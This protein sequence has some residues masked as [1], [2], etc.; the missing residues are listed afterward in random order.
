MSK[1]LIV[2]G[3]VLT[4]L[5]PYD[6]EYSRRN[7]LY[8]DYKE[9][10]D[11]LGADIEIKKDQ[12][13]NDRLDYLWEHGTWL[14]LDVIIAFATNNKYDKML[15]IDSDVVINRG[16]AY[17]VDPLELYANDSERPEIAIVY[18]NFLPLHY[19]TFD[20][21]S[22]KKYDFYEFMFGDEVKL[23]HKINSAMFVINKK[24]AKVIHETLLS[25]PVSIICG[26]ESLYGH[27]PADE[28][29]IELAMPHLKHEFFDNIT[30]SNSGEVKAFTHYCGIDQKR[31]LFYE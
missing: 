12:F 5:Y 1:K 4:G 27:F 22:K 26:Y 23:Y 16:L 3:H 31:T 24:A 7:E 14:K 6:K 28:S 20:E 19:H 18:D 29:I 9:Y 30:E 13:S 25:L 10:A 11:F 15:W 8:A 2:S 17:K 21:F